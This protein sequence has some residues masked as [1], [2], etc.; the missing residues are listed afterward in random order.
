MQLLLVGRVSHL[1]SNHRIKLG[2]A[3]TIKDLFTD[4]VTNNVDQLI[5]DYSRGVC[6]ISWCCAYVMCKITFTC[7]NPELQHS[8]EVTMVGTCISFCLLVT[9]KMAS[10]GNVLSATKQHSLHNGHQSL[11][12]GSNSFSQGSIYLVVDLL[13]LA[14]HH[15]HEVDSL[16]DSFTVGPHFF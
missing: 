14:L 1:I 15:L 16:G 2:I 12:V 13:L 3:H 5:L 4:K 10:M 9:V 11:S 7:I 8:S 6:C